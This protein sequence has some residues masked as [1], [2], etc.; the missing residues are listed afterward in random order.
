[1]QIDTQDAIHAIDHIDRQLMHIN[2]CID[3]I[4]CASIRVLQID[5]DTQ[6]D[7]CISLSISMQID[8]DTQINLHID[9]D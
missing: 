2:L 1:M 4:E 3:L 5:T 9:S 7:M 6:I 8:T